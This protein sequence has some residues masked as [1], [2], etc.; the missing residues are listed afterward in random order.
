MANENKEKKAEQLETSSET[1]K[2][3]QPGKP[4]RPGK[5]KPK[6][7][8]C[9][10]G[11]GGKPNPSN[12]NKETSQNDPMWYAPSEEIGKA[13][14]SLP[15]NRFP[16]MP[17]SLVGGDA[18]YRDLS[19]KSIPGTLALDYCISVGSN[20]TATSAINIAARQL[21]TFVRHANS[22]HANY[23][24]SDLIMY[25]LAMDEVYTAWLEAK[26]IY[27]VAGSFSYS[28][29]N[30]PDTILAALKADGE[31]VRR[32]YAHYRGELNLLAKQ[33]S[34]MAVP[35]IYTAMARH[36]L[37]ASLVLTDSTEKKSQFYVATRAYGHIFDAKATT[38]GKLTTYTVQ[39]NR[40]VSQIIAEIRNMLDKILPDEDMNIISGD[41]L[42][43]FGSENLYVLR[44]IPEEAACTPVFD[45]GVL[46]Q[47]KNALTC[48]ATIQNLDIEQKDNLV[49]TN[50]Y[51]VTA[52]SIAGQL[53]VGPKIFAAKKENA[54]WKEILESTR[55]MTGAVRDASEPNMYLQ[56]FGTEVCLKFRIE[57]V[58]YSEATPKVSEI[59]FDSYEGHYYD[60]TVSGD[61]DDTAMTSL[62]NI[63]QYSKFK[64]APIV[65]FYSYENE[66]PAEVVNDFKGFMGEIDNFTVIDGP[67]R[68]KLHDV[69]VMGEF[70]RK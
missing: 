68:A 52:T 4:K 11:N 2:P 69:A 55:F 33:I 48:Q 21:Y 66:P 34:S 26:R 58:S 61:P 53:L 38:G 57:Y 16:G 64:Y 7:G 70:W 18:K 47:F 30:I 49:T 29:R 1:R 39:K 50:L 43:A 3:A 67:T 13:M 23:E 60:V 41:I 40:S 45:E 65:Y 51:K 31:D 63:A 35:N 6:N 59:A 22:G 25:L 10:N 44:E 8:L 54:D 19:G 9:G 37:L 42:K 46:M 28:N 32:N 17:I 62:E 56:A 5:H 14:A 12:E 15:F 27:E 20:L 36:A 24:S